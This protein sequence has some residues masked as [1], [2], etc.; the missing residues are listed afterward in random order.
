MTSLDAPSHRSII[1]RRVNS[2]FEVLPAGTFDSVTA[3]EKTKD[4]PVK[5]FSKKLQK[6]QSKGEKRDSG[7]AI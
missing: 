5:R 6:R 1:S 4:R 7:V 2:G 3:Q